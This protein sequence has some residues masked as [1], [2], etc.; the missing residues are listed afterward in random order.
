MAEDDQS[1]EPDPETVFSMVLEKDLANIVKKSAAGQPLNK[2]EREMIEAQLASQR[3]DSKSGEFHLEAAPSALTGLTQPEFAE[4]W[5]YSLRTIKNWIADGRKASSP[6]PLDRPHEMAAWFARI[7]SPRAAPDKLIQAVR[8]LQSEVP[9]SPSQQSVMPERIEVLDS[10]K[11]M[12]AMLDRVRTAEATLYGQYLQAVEANDRDTADYKNTEWL[13]AAERLRA[14]EKSAPQALA[15]AGIYVR[16]DDVTRELLQLHSGII[17][18][19]KQALRK[20]RIKLQATKSTDEFNQVSDTI[21]DDA[22]SAL[23]DDD[24][25]EPLELVAE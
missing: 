25:A 23:C 17:K 8:K 19:F 16:K 11:G 4:K 21:V 1:P 2:R 3:P 12:L 18:H 14:L 7:Y 15:D 22:C 24:F 5:G 9:S 20:S 6:P 13:K 10:Q